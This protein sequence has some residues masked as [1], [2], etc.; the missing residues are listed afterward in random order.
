MSA[1]APGETLNRLAGD[2]KIFQLK[3]GHRFSTDDLMTAWTAAHARPSARRLLDIGSGIGSVGLLALW[4]L[5]AAEAHLT[6]LEVQS[7]SR[8]LMLKTIA[9]NGLEHRTDPRLG[10]L[11]AREH[12]PQGPV[13]ELVTGSPP[14]I[15]IGR[16]VQS[17]HPQKAA[18]R[19][20]LHGSVFDYCITG[21]RMLAPDGCF[22]LVHAA[23]DPR[24]E[25]AIAAAGLTLRARRDVHFRADQ[26]PLIALFECAHSG[27]RHDHPPFFIRGTDG[28]WTDEYLEMRRDMGTEV[29]RPGEGPHE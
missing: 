22:A 11:R 10:D 18:A 9:H 19:I 26:P 17:P 21:A 15:P 27:E 23:A 3:K 14:Y 13:F 5:A 24:P 4:R 7:L 6:S 12:L 16:G 28:Q 2:W 29:W 25:Q 8:D 1:P 20:E